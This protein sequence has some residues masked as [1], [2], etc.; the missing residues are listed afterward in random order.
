MSPQ[1]ADAL[2]FLMRCL[3]V[4]LI[5]TAIGFLVPRVPEGILFVLILCIAAVL[6]S[7]RTE[8]RW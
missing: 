7:G 4:A 6:M 5:I 3:G 8:I 2:I 1:I